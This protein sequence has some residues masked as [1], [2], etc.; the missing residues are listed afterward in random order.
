M[1]FIV[2]EIQSA[3]SVSVITNNYDERLDAES[4]FHTILAAAAISSVPKH[5]AS[6]LTDEGEVIKSQCYTH[7]QEEPVNE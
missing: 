4:K 2:L 6:L 7:K 5:S 3:D 1:K